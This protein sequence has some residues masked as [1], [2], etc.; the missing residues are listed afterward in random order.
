MFDKPFA[1]IVTTAETDL[2]GAVTLAAAARAAGATVETPLAHS[3]PQRQQRRAT[4]NATR[5]VLTLDGETV[6][7]LDVVSGTRSTSS[8]LEAGVTL[9]R[10]YTADTGKPMRFVRGV[11]SG[12][13]PRAA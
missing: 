2:M 3:Q 10:T 13:L 11:R 8:A 5:F 1:I 12:A 9:A 6:E 4:G 7:T